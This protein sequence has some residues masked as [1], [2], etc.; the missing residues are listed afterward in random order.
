M[1]NGFPDPFFEVRVSSIELP[2]LSAL[3]AGFDSGDWRAAPLADHL[4]QW[5]PFAALSQEHQLSFGASNFVEML[6]L[7]SA[8]IYNSRKTATRG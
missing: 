1:A 2:E 3:C 7:A 8:H 5:I 4:F 6:K